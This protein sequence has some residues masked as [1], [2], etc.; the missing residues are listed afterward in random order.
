MIPALSFVFTLAFIAV[1]FAVGLRLLALWR[2]TRGL[3]EFT[4]GLG[5]FMIVGLGYPIVLAG[6]VLAES[7][8]GPGA[9]ALMIVS[10]A[11]MNVGW[12]GVWVFTWRVFR[13]DSMLARLAAGAAIAGLALVLVLRA[14]DTL[15]APDLASLHVVGIGTLGTPLLALGSYV[16]TAVE[17][18]RYSALLRKRAAVGL[19][20]PV[21][22]NRF[23]LWGCVGV[24]SMLSLMPSIVRQLQG[25]AGL[26]PM[27]QL[28]SA[29]AGLGCAISLYLAF[30]PPQAYVAWLKR[31]SAGAG[32]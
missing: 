12:M 21:V 22:A 14:R 25:F 8:F 7:S 9:R 32:A 19:G 11:L 28:L 20:D 27:A 29:L 1:G 4:L 31:G 10:S 24:F 17:A 3:A 13:P 26:E 16:W 15:L 18:F 30:L 5:L 6:Y 23:T 2:R